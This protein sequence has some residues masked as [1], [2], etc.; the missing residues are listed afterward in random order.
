MWDRITVCP[1]NLLLFYA[2]CIFHFICI[3]FCDVSV[4]FLSHDTVGDVFFRT[5]LANLIGNHIADRD[6]FLMGVNKC[7]RSCMD[8]R[9]HRSGFHD[10]RHYADKFRDDKGSGNYEHDNADS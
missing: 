5:G 9:F 2:I 8:L 6:V 1:N 10:I 7:H 4:R 3:A